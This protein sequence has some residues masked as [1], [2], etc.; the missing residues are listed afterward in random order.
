LT[1][2]PIFHRTALLVGPEALEAM[3]RTRVILFGAGGV[4]SW[5]AE[6]LIRS[7]IG[8]LTLVDS[9]V[10]CITN[11]NRQL[12][13]H[14]GNVGQFKV[15]E[16]ATR[17][18]AINPA[19]TIEPINQ[20]Y[21]F[22]GVDRF[23][24][25][26]FDYVV[27]AIDSVANKVL[28]IVK[29]I[30]SG[31]PLFSAMGASCKLDATRIQVGS[32]WDVIGCSLAKHVRK[33]VRTRLRK[34]GIERDFLCVYSDE[35]QAGYDVPTVCGT[36]Q[37]YCPGPEETEGRSEE[38]HEWCSTKA[39]INGSLVHVTGTFGFHLA[40]LVIQDIVARTNGLK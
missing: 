9:D 4:G 40:G 7:G 20:V 25:G 18:R 14:T 1:E 8:Q 36:G 17:L 6:A 13:A 3:G 28:L 16:L 29:T 23:D 27:D 15:E 26:A 35:R 11:V 37:C 38:A 10:V 31:T 22:D 34:K 21:N 19:A 5:C 12:Q 33:R 39:E 32:F 24:L 30:E 2:S